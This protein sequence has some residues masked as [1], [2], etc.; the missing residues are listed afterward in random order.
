MRRDGKITELNMDVMGHHGHM[1]MADP[2][3][4]PGSAPG[5]GAHNLHA[6][7][8]AHR[9]SDAGFAYGL[10]LILAG[11]LQEIGGQS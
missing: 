5:A 6:G 8:A 2:H 11:L 10:R 7:G 4:M 3:E 9:P 1:Q